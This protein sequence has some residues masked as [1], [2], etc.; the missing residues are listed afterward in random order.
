MKIY[1]FFEP[2]SSEKNRLTV[3][4]RF[5]LK[6]SADLKYVK[7]DNQS[8]KINALVWQDHWTDEVT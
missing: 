4:V 5:L 6:Y 1:I 8:K 7:H 2:S 3:R